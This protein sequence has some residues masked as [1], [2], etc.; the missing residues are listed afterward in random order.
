MREFR[1]RICCEEPLTPPDN[2][3]FIHGVWRWDRHR[4]LGVLVP[5]ICVSL[6]L[7]GRTQPLRPYG[8]V[9]RLYRGAIRC[10]FDRDVGSVRRGGWLTLPGPRPAL[11]Y[12]LEDELAE[13]LARTR[14]GGHNELWVRAARAEIVGGYLLEGSQAAGATAFRRACLRAGWA[15][16]LLR[17]ARAGPRPTRTWRRA[18]AAATPRPPRPRCRSPAGCRPG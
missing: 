17:G 4:L 10:A 1:S 9:L 5:E 18:S 12:Y 16:R 7:E 2:S 14:P 6:H 13:L 15:V 8:Y 11:R 3:L